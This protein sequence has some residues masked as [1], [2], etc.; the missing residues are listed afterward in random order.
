VKCHPFRLF[1][2][3]FNFFGESVGTGEQLRPS[4]SVK[5]AMISRIIMRYFITLDLTQIFEK[6][7]YQ[8]VYFTTTFLVFS[9]LAFQ[10]MASKDK[11]LKE[12]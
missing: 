1:K 5:K 10:S 11:N 4:K 8:S 6:A 2:G 12:L 7:F 9:R 3:L